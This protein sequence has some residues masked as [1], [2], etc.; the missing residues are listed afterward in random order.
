V[1]FCIRRPSIASMMQ[2]RTYRGRFCTRARVRRGGMQKCTVSGVRN[3]NRPR[4]PSPALT[5]RTYAVRNVNETPRGAVRLTKCTTNRTRL[6]Q[7]RG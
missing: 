5:L 1:H 2:L 4:R 7:C 6:P 3:V